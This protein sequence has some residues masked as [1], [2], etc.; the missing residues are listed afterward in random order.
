MSIYGVGYAQRLLWQTLKRPLLRI[1]SPSVTYKEKVQQAEP[2]Q[3][4]QVPEPAKADSAYSSPS[5]KEMVHQGELLQGFKVL[6][7]GEVISAHT[8]SSSNL[9]E[10]EH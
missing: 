1:G 5:S 8:S 9:E 6:G 10:T 2:Q 7:S 3:V 4:F